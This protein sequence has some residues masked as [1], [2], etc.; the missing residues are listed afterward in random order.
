M[1]KGVPRPFNMHSDVSN[2]S[3]LAFAKEFEPQPK[4]ILWPE[5]HRR[6]ANPGTLLLYNNLA[7]SKSR[8]YKLFVFFFIDKSHVPELVQPAR[9]PSASDRELTLGQ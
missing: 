1:K 8:K 9:A 3:I 6:E 5:R 2:S 4:P 7:E